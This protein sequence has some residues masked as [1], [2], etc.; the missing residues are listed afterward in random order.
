M[1]HQPIQENNNQGKE[2]TS[3]AWFGSAPAARAALASSTSRENTAS[4]SCSVA[5]SSNAAG[6]TGTEVGTSNILDSPIQS[7]SMSPAG[8]IGQPRPG[9]QVGMRRQEHT[10]TIRRSFLDSQIGDPFCG[11]LLWIC[12][13]LL[14]PTHRLTVHPPLLLSSDPL[15]CQLPFCQN[16]LRRVQDCCC[17]ARAGA[18]SFVWCA[19]QKVTSCSCVLL[20]SAL[21]LRCAG[22]PH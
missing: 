10:H 22:A 8:S 19:V 4:N 13:T 20:Y 2:H 12:D 6:F 11:Y 7:I 3:L 14:R 18:S 9:R 17:A 21:R 16:V 1:S 5:L 15:F